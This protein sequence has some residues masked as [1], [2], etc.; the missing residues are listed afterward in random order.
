MLTYKNQKTGSI[1]K[2]DSVIL[3]NNWEEVKTS[4]KTSETKKESKKE[5]KTE[6]KK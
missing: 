3:S 2:I 1:I 6:K 4:E 5:V